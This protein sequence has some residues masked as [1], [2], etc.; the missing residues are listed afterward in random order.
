M[1]KTKTRAYI[2]KKIDK[3]SENS[4][5]QSESQK[6]YASMA[7]MSSNVESTR[8]N[9]GDISQLINSILDLGVTFHMI[10]EISDFVPGS[11]LETD[12]YIKVADGNFFTAKQTGKVQIK[13]VTIMVT[14]YS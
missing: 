7:C 10:Q 3:T 5:Y 4:T 2:L 9:C 13:C 1:E 6:I 8:R 12:K 11:L 14:F